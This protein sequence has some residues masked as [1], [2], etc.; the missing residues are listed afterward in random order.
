MTIMNCDLTCNFTILSQNVAPFHYSLLNHVGWLFPWRTQIR[1][2]PSAPS[3]VT[4]HSSLKRAGEKLVFMYQFSQPI[5]CFQ[6]IYLKFSQCSK[7]FI[8]LLTVYIRNSSFIKYFLLVN[9]HFLFPSNFSQLF[10]WYS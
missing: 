1:T 4:L 5:V 7:Y 3:Y 10:L 8:S 6:D 2:Q 9:P